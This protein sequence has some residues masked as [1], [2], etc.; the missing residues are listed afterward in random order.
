[1][2]RLAPAV[3]SELSP[4]RLDRILMISEWDLVDVQTRVQRRIGWPQQVSDKA[5]LEYRKFI[6]LVALNPT[7]TYGMVEAIDEV[8]HEHILNTR[9]YLA[10]CDA[11]IGTVIHHE[12]LPLHSSINLS[13]LRQCTLQDIEKTFDGPVSELW[14]SGDGLSFAKCCN[15]HIETKH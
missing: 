12:Q 9:D 15:G 6:A 13:A 2:L 10:M 3:I 4:D 14:L 5:V 1:M 8:W 11:V 7:K